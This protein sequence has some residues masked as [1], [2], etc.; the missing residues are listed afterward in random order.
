M[1]VN[2]RLAS[3]ARVAVLSAA[4][5]VP[6][7]TA[8]YADDG[9]FV[10]RE[11]VNLQSAATASPFSTVRDAAKSQEDA[12]L[13]STV[14]TVAGKRDVVGAGGHQDELNRLIYQPGHTVGFGG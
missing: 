3:L 10:D 13:A 12:R 11:G 8:A 14:P 9:F 7:V 1:S 5:A 6:A 4:L 2:L